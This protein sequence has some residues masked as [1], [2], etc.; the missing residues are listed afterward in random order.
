MI[1]RRVQTGFD[2]ETGEARFEEE[3]IRPEKLPFIIIVID[4]MA[5][6]M[7]VSGKEIEGV[8]QRLAQMARAPACI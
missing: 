8:V 6:L 5:D 7:L 2:P 3:Q 4:E 1:V